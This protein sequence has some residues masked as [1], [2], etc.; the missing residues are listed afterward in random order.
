MT[1]EN[2][3]VDGPFPGLDAY[4]DGQEPS[5]GAA[6]RRGGTPSDVRV[7]RLDTLPAIRNEMS[8]L[9]RAA[10]RVAGTNPSP[11]EATKLG[12]LLNALATAVTNTE[13]A[14]RVAAL[15]AKEKR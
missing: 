1:L 4:R 8:R 10:R 9:Y 13:L 11:S 7:G 6:S 14:E 15:E 3:P 5:N 2:E 12:W